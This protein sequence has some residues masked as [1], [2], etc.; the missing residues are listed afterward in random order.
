M[1]RVWSVLVGV[2]GLGVAYAFTGRSRPPDP[3]LGW[4]LV[5]A[6]GALWFTRTRV[7]AGLV[8]A[9]AGLIY[10]EVVPSTMTVTIIWG[11]LAL[12]FFDGDDLR[13]VLRVQAAA[14]YFFAAVNKL[15][16]AFLSGAMLETEVEWLP[17]AQ[18]VSIVTIVAEAGLA[19]AVLARWRWTPHAVVA[20]HVPIAVCTAISPLHFV[21]LVAYGGMML[22]LVAESLRVGEDRDVAAGPLGV[23]G[24]VDVVDH[25]SDLD[26]TGHRPRGAS[27]HR[28]GR[29]PVGSH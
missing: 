22:W 4:L 9:V 5:A 25:R 19:V 7:A 27:V 15:W 16:P 12:A 17:Y 1:M 8:A 14:I 23:V 26:I 18:A 3:A 13:L 11:S 28:D 6:C 20:L 29:R 21:T 10:L 24:L 2:F